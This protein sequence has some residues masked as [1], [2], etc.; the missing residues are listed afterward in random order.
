M[1]RAGGPSA[2]TTNN[3]NQPTPEPEPP[4]PKRRRDKQLHADSPP[5]LFRPKKVEKMT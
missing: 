3:T 4:A 5:L 2:D 1:N